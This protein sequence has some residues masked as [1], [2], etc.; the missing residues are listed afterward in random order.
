MKVLKIVTFAVIAFS[1]SKAHCQEKKE[2]DDSAKVDSDEQKIVWLTFDDGFHTHDRVGPYIGRGS[3]GKASL[4]IPFGTNI[5]VILFLDRWTNEFAHVSYGLGLH[6]KLICVGKLD[7][8]LAPSLFTNGDNGG[9]LLPTV[10]A[11]RIFDNRLR[12]QVSASYRAEA[13][14]G[15]ASHNS[16]AFFTY[17]V[18]VGLALSKILPHK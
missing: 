5:G 8:L 2:M 18:G 15:I 17:T 10:I 14:L 16:Y 12:V 9:V 3:Y 4:E 6:A 13:E 7:V 11:Y 1:L